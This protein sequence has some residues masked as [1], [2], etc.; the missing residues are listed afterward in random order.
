MTSLQKYANTK[1][2]GINPVFFAFY[3]ANQALLF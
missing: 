2:P 3:Q 1:K